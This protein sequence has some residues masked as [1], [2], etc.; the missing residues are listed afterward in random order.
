MGLLS[1]N[2]V[3]KDNDAYTNNEKAD[4]F[5]L[6][7]LQLYKD[8]KLSEAAMLEIIANKQS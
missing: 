3:T 6:E 2:A 8:G 7:T 4:S 1:G 5:L